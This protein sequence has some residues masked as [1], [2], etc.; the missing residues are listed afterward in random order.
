[1]STPAPVLEVRDLSVTLA[2][3]HGRMRAVEDVSFTLAAGEVLGIVGESGAG[4]SLTLRSLIDLLPPG[5]T[6]DGERRADLHGRGLAPYDPADTRGRGIAM[7]FQEPAT[8]LNPTMRVGDLVAEGLRLHSGLSR[9]AARQRAVDLLTD[10][11]IPQAARRARMWP[12]QLSG[13]LR[14]RVTIAAALSTSPRVLLCDEPTTALDVSVQDQILGL[15]LRLRDE[16]G[17]SIVIVS[18]DLAVLGEVCDRLMVMYCG[19]VVEVG[20]AHDILSAPTHPYTDALIRSS[21]SVD[22]RVEGLTPIRG[23]VPPLGSPPPGC[24]FAPRCGFAEPDCTSATHALAEV[25]PGRLTG[26][27]HPDRLRAERPA[28]ASGALR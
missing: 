3:A 9:R 24:R 10:V 23:Q 25:A 27:I 26:C 18:H 13:G 16:I 8:A 20:A 11:G 1:M 22:R 6:V 14:Q 4:K 7:V 17:L 19:R 5:A 15:L 12:H 2:T 28:S 21:P